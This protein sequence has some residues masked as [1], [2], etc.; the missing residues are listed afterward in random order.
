MSHLHCSLVEASAQT[1]LAK[2]PSWCAWWSP[3]EIDNAVSTV[4]LKRIERLDDERIGRY[5]VRVGVGLPR[6]YIVNMASLACECKG[7]M[8]WHVLACCIWYHAV[9]ETAIYEAEYAAYDLNE[10]ESLELIQN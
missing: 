2:Y 6:A 3:W 9:V 7:S 1:L 4:K 10:R 8:C 5:R